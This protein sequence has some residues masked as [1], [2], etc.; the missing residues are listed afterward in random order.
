[1]F[2]SVIE[3]RGLRAGRFGTGAW[4]SAGVH[5]GLLGL[6]FFLSGRAP[7][8]E[9]TKPIDVVLRAT[10]V[11]QGVT[12]PAASPQAQPA[13]PA[14]KPKPRPRVDRM[15]TQVKPLPANPEP[16]PADPTPTT[17]ADAAAPQDGG[18]E[19]GPLGHPLGDPDSDQPIGLIPTRDLNLAPTGTDVLPFQGG[20]TPPVMLSGPAI[21]YTRE[22]KLAGVQGTLIVRC[23]ISSEGDVRDCRVL[24]GLPYMDEE[25]VQSLSARKYRPMTFQGRAVNVS[26]TFNVKL[27]MP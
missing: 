5:A 2:E 23:V 14:P 11:R 12:K 8:P 18:G 10:A 25:V 26:Y 3:R 17:T 7:E 1:M 4:V 20:M 27:R 19:V 16:A 22:A 13:A 15:P 6:V 21:E 24:K 9:E